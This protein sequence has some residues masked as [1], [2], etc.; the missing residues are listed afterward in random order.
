MKL[1]L[2]HVVLLPDQ[3][4]LCHGPAR[5]FFCEAPGIAHGAVSEAAKERC[6]AYGP[7]APKPRAGKRLTGGGM[8]GFGTLRKRAFR[9]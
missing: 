5:L 8:P 3:P 2:P 1:D 7:K 6:P 9:Q 4:V